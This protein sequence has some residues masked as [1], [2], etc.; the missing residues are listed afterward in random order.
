MRSL[1]V[2]ADPEIPWF[3][4]ELRANTRS[5]RR[6]TGSVRKKYKQDCYFLAKGKDLD[7]DSITIIFYPPDKR[8]RD[9]DNCLS[10]IKY[11]IDGVCEAVGIDDYQFVKK[12]IVRGDPVS[13]GKII[14]KK[15]IDRLE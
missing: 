8:K 7:C 5:D 4:K 14:I 9:L 10:S 6:W 3:P 2:F 11:G 12:L 1:C 13:G 15:G